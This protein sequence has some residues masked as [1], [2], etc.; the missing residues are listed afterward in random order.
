MQPHCDVFLLGTDDSFC[1]RL[2]ADELVRRVSAS[3]D[4]GLHQDF[5]AVPVVRWWSE[6]EM[7]ASTDD[8][9]AYSITEGFVRVD[10]IAAIVPVGQTAAFELAWAEAQLTGG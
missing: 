4:A 3:A 1:V 5:L 10:Q 6:D 9:V 2:S 8:R 7:L